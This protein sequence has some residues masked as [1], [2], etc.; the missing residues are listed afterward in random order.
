MF[1]DVASGDFE[2]VVEQEGWVAVINDMHKGRDTG[3]VWKWVID[4]SAGFLVLISITGLV[5]QCFL[6]KRRRSAL[7]SAGIGGAIV[8]FLIA[9]VLT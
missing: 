5:M 1:F 2:L 8:I 9:L 7:I 4:L 6:R 3:T